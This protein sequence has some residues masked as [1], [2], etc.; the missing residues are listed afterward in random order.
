MSARKKRT[1]IRRILDVL[2]D[3]KTKEDYSP[4]VL[5][6]CGVMCR[7]SEVGK[8]V[9][10]KCLKSGI[11][12]NTQKLQKLLVL[13]QVESIKQSDFPLFSEDI[14]KWDCG[15]AI[16]EVD[17]DFRASGIKFTDE[18]IEHVELLSSEEEYIDIILEKYGHL[19]AEEL[20]ALDINQKILSNMV[21]VKEGDKVPHISADKLIELFKE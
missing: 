4:L 19:S 3:K 12:I 16:K 2:M 6:E 7:A 18:L 17:E 21:E 14:R 9:V 10:N 15:V 5:E 13:I 1:K 20:N 11:P 8:I